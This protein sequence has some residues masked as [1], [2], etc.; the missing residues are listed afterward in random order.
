MKVMRIEIKDY[1]LKNLLMQLEKT[2]KFH[3]SSQKSGTWNF[4][5][6]KVNNEERVMHSK[7]VRYKS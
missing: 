2:W 7:N 1:Q 6:S 5:S 3:K 4:M